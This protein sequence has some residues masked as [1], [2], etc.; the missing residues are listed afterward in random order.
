MT[1]SP[2]SGIGATATVNSTCCRCGHDPRDTG[3]DWAQCTSCGKVYCTECIA[4]RRKRGIDLLC[5][6][7]GTAVL[8]AAD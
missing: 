7:C 1:D 2:C 8:S 4:E 3:S 6:C 5:P